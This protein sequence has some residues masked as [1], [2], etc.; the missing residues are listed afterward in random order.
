MIAPAMECLRKLRGYRP[1]GTRKWEARCP[2]H[3]DRK[4]SLSIGM[5][6]DGRILLNCFA[7]CK[8]ER[9]LKEVGIDVKD[10]FPGNGNSEHGS[11]REIPYWKKIWD[12]SVPLGSTE[13]EPGRRYLANR[14]LKLEAFPDD[15]RFHPKLPYFNDH[16]IQGEYPA[17]IAIVRD[18]RGKPTGAHRIHLTVNGGKADV[19]VVKKA[20]GSMA[21]GGIFFCEYGNCLNIAEGIET[22][23]A[24]W[25]ATK[26]PTCS[27]VSAAGM[28]S[29]VIPE[30]VS[31]VHIWAD[32]DHSRSGEVAALELARR[33]YEAGKTAYIHLP[34]GPLAEGQKCRDYLD[35]LNEDGTESFR[36]SLENGESW[37][38][39]SPEWPA[40][41]LFYEAHLPVFPVSVLPEWQREFV[42]AEA[43]AT[44][45]PLDLAAMLSLSV[46]AGA[47]AK[48]VAVQVRPGFVEPVNLY[49][50]ISLPSANR[51]SR[52][53][54]DMVEPMEEREAEEA[55]IAA[56]EIA[57]ANARYKVLERML[58]RK[59]D[60]AARTEDP[61]ERSRLSEEASDLAAEISEVKLPIPPRLLADDTTPERLQTLLRDHDGRVAIMSAEGD[62]FDA[63][64]GRYSSN[65]V[66]NLAV[67]LKGHGGDTL[68]V[69]RTGRPP[70]FIKDPA[71][72]LGITVQPETISGLADKPGF[73]GRGLLARILF[74]LPASTIGHRCVDAEPVRDDI[75]IRY[76]A[77]VASLLVIP[78][79]F[80]ENGNAAPRLLRLEDKAEAELLCFMKWLEP[81]LGSLGELEFISDWA[82]KLSGAIARI[83]GLLHMAEHA[84]EHEP[85]GI[86]I[87]EKTMDAA[88]RIGEY[89]IPHAKA[90]FSEMGAALSVEM[91]RD[92]LDWLKLTGK[93]DFSKRELFNAR[94]G[95]FR[96][97]K[98][99]DEPLDLLVEHGYIRQRDAG[100]QAGPG[101]K[102]SPNYDV[103]PVLAGDCV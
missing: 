14:G 97:A 82:G 6:D 85:W 75:R 41:A 92:I 33:A 17:L 13:A 12:E 26:M 22:A 48:K 7:G 10:L 73:R 103:N 84:R 95:R 9:I 39:S 74:S 91:A 93:H 4:A 50:V 57:R 36:R 83:A 28:R 67:Y 56:P 21:G 47:C 78:L 101:R 37:K 81:Q 18:S 32:L 49:C 35:V 99:L 53:F 69:D 100:R 20:I 77:N 31:T 30:C 38:P 27:T 59:Q 62:I 43:T 34:P 40:P 65:G 1:T 90:A 68:R 24:V 19:E 86:Q 46:L 79:E 11:D 5:G 70:E 52:V 2:A 29:F 60:A 54:R 3:N 64:A 88:I 61:A 55:R 63:M 15:V 72:T 89:L 25:Q 8:L 58:N 76:I 96:M 87:A 80:D 102:P 45:T 16:L 98:E 71:L 44:Q 94:R 66:P 51:K 42:E 23:L